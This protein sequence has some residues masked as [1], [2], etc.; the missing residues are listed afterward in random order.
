[1]LI[2]YRNKSEM[3]KKRLKNIKIDKKTGTIYLESSTTKGQ[4]LER[5]LKGRHK[6]KLSKR[7]IARKKANRNRGYW[8]PDKQN[9]SFFTVYYHLIF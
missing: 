9:R 1:M 5:R 2:C 8:R 7:A 4:G 3:K 6:K